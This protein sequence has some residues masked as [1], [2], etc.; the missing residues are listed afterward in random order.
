MERAA[1]LHLSSRAGSLALLTLLAVPM[2]HAPA[3]AEITVACAANFTSRVTVEDKVPNAIYTLYVAPNVTGPYTSL[4]SGNTI[5]TDS[6]G[7]GT[8]ELANTSGGSLFPTTGHRFVKIGNPVAPSSQ[9]A[10]EIEFDGGT[11]YWPGNWFA[12]LTPGSSGPRTVR[13]RQAVVFNGKTFLETWDAG[14]VVSFKLNAIDAKWVNLGAAVVPHGDLSAS[15]ISVTDSRVTV[16][17]NSDP[18]HTTVDDLE[19]SG[20]GINVL[21]LGSV[22][23][24][25]EW[26]GSSSQ[27]LDGT[28]LSSRTWGTPQSYEFGRFSPP[29]PHSAPMLGDW[30]IASLMGLVACLGALYLGRRWHVSR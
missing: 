17:I 4:G 18:T 20:I 13:L 2:F 21:T 16:Q 25:L 26:T 8:I 22:G 24:D 29:V 11:P 19:I 7:D 10:A 12:S 30:G 5:A 6:D 23:V 9:A 28:L 27:Y 3:H 1:R 14:T 15:L